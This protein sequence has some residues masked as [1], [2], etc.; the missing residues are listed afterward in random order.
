MCGIFGSRVEHEV[1]DKTA[2]KRVSNILSHRGPDAEGFYFSDDARLALSHRRL[3]VIDLRDVA[4]QPMSTPDGRWTIVY[5]GE[6]YNFKE[7]RQQLQNAGV[8]PFTTDSDTEVVLLAW[9]KWGPEAANKF[10]GM[11]AFALWDNLKEELWLCRDRVGVKPLFYSEL[12]GISF[13]SELKGL[14]PLLA[15][16]PKI[17]SSAINTFLH[18]GFIPEPETIFHEIKKFPAGHYGSYTH[19][20][21]LKLTSY[22]RQED[23]IAPLKTASDAQVVGQFSELLESSVRYR[24]ISDVPFGTFLSGGTDSSLVTAVAAGLSTQPLKT[25]SIGFHEAKFDESKYAAAVARQLKTD[26]TEFILSEKDA[27]PLLDEM[28]NTFDEPFADT[29]AIPTMLISRLAREQVTVILT[30]D[31]GDELF[32]GYGAYDWARRL[33]NPFVQRAA[34]VIGSALSLG[35]SR[36]KRIAHLFEKDGLNDVR[37][38]ILSQEQY[39]FSNSEIKRLLV[40][41]DHQIFYRYQDPEGLGRR[42]SHKE[43]QAL[44]DL[45]VYLK[46]DLLTKVDRSSMKYGLEC[47]EPLLDYRLVEFALNLN[48]HYKVRDGERK[49]LLKKT[50]ESY[51]PRDLIYRPK[52]GFSVPL[53]RWLRNEWRFVI[54]EN[55]SDDVVGSVGL[56]NVDAVRSIKRRF[57]HGEE[58]LYN[59]LW[60]LTILHKWLS[61]QKD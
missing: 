50:L 48:G 25:F 52:W 38:H 26:H 17:S 3:S 47:R 5:N 32:M 30:G 29:S 35:P 11:F 12:G 41:K 6:V 22:W 55:L 36:Y 31:G 54:E 37:G 58:Y 1:I 20:T 45:K 7:I 19:K 39:F 15:A 51:L 40:A 59:R 4:N 53:A 13:A 34:P 16:K 33:S 8:G 56:V 46:D 61:Q 10:N 2:F 21:G 42:L 49:W 44:F 14:L 9:I 24:M 28:I 27:I 23:Q 18:L 60:A 43:L 57:F